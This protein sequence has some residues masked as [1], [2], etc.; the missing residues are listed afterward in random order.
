MI[1]PVEHFDPLIYHKKSIDR[2]YSNHDEILPWPWQQSRGEKQ[3]SCPGC[4]LAEEIWRANNQ[5]ICRLRNVTHWSCGSAVVFES[6][7]RGPS[8]SGADVSVGRFVAAVKEHS[9]DILG[10]SALLTT[11]MPGMEATIQ[12]LESAGIRR[13]V[14][15]VVGGAPVT[16]HFADRIG[17]DGYGADGGAAIEL[18]RKLI[19]K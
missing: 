13:Q 10:I 2:I 11:T 9:P 5:K 15:V 12:A 7:D 16:Q 6:G 14:K 8:G 19:G 4:P 3:K 18:C 17:A 1:C